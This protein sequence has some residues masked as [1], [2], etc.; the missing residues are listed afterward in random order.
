MAIK[1]LN[2]SKTTV[3]TSSYDTG[4]AKDKTKFHLGTLDSRLVSM[5]RDK[6]TTVTMNPT[7]PDD[8]VDSQINMNIVN[9]EACVY[10][11]RDIENFKDDAGNDIKVVFSKRNHGGVSYRVI[12]P[13]T[14][15]LI[16][17]VVVNELGAKIMADNELSDTDVKN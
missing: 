10:G 6:A 3:F 12:D 4:E 16:P 1:A 13:A 2:L 11:L 17:Q 8:E 7:K 5:L 14:I 15:A 9:F